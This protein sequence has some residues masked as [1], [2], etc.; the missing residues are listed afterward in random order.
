MRISSLRSTMS[1]APPIINL[2][3]GWPAPALLPAAQIQSAARSVLDNPVLAVPALS[4][5]ADEGYRP[6]RRQLAHWLHDFY[7]L[8]DAVADENRFCITGGASQNLAALLSV[9]TDPVYTRRVWLVAPCYFLAGRVFEDA[10][11]GGVM[12]AVREDEEG[13]DVESLRDGMEKC[14]SEA[15]EDRKVDFLH[16]TVLLLLMLMSWQSFKPARSY[17]K[18]YRHVIYAVPTFSNPSGTTMS[19]RRRQALVELARAH[20]ALIIT[21]DVYDMLQWHISPSTNSP[22]LHHALLPRIVDIDRTLSGARLPFGNAVSNGSFSK[23]AGPGMR[24][25]WA[26]GRESFIYG[27]SQVGSSCS[28]GAPSQ[29][30]ATFLAHMLQQ[31]TLQEH[32]RKVLLPAYARRHG[33]MRRAVQDVLE[34][35]GVRINSDA[36]FEGIFGGYFLWLRLPSPVSA[37]EVTRRA[38]EEENVVVGPGQLFAVPGDEDAVD[39]S[40]CVRLCFAYED[41]DRLMEGVQRLGRVVQKM[42]TANSL[43]AA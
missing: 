39:L 16:L 6:L 33:I 17:A 26:E 9:Y 4:Y 41:E 43:D 29:M 38:K 24:T 19:L 14:A 7:R 30:S 13:I 8:P 34:P 42:V 21:D 10:G 35:L 22:A 27:L 3:R 23:I 11:L 28:G 32:V 25:G 40:R 37:N 1:S 36:G 15:G 18:L 31:G 12:R 20:D 5:G 2:M